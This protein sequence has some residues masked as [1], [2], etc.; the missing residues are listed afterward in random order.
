M[1]EPTEVSPPSTRVPDQAEFDASTYVM[2]EAGKALRQQLDQ[3]ASKPAD[4]VLVERRV[5]MNHPDAKPFAQRAG[6]SA[7]D[8]ETRYWQAVAERA[9]QTGNKE[10][11]A[12]AERGLAAMAAKSAD[13]E[14]VDP[15]TGEV[16]KSEP[17]APTYDLIVDESILPRE[18][19][20][21][22]HQF[23]VDVAAI[24]EQN[25]IP[26]DRAQAAFSATSGLF[27][28]DREIGITNG[29]QAVQSM[30]TRF[31]AEQ[32][33]RIIEDARIM[34]KALGPDFAKWA[35]ETGAG[36]SPAA[37]F[38]LHCL[39]TGDMHLTAAE[40][41]AKVK[42]IR[43]GKDGATPY[44]ITRASVLSRI[45]HPSRRDSQQSPQTRAYST[46]GE[47]K[48]LGVGS[49]TAAELRRELKALNDINSDLHSSDG[50]KRARAVKRR[51]QIVQQLG[52][53]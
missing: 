45:A 52:G 32:A 38:V 46:S 7:A 13:G 25:A 48:M 21:E 35:D 10:H 4:P 19:L 6:E 15:Q 37:L 17:S 40:A 22:A 53:Q 20:P 47:D 30:V 12:M 50:P 33:G 49:Q 42:E 34:T 5:Q 41:A 39:K 3:Q 11:A 29:D 16:T 44:G 28:Q 51:Q 8:R 36:D 27:M 24:A 18:I 14:I 43:S 9:Q 2:S 26:M 1:T 31:G 23:A